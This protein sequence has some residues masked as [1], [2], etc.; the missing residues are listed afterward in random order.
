MVVRGEHGLGHE[1]AGVVIKLGPGVTSFKEGCP[2]T[3]AKAKFKAT[4]LQLNLES[5]APNRNVITV[6]QDDI[7]R[8]LTSHFIQHRHT[9]ER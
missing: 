7:M 5:L 6:E 8:V 3:F 9:P 1:S 2:S 4:E